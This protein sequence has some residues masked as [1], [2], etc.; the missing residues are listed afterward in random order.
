MKRKG[1][2]VRKELKEFYA[3]NKVL[4]TA[5]F[6][7]LGMAILVSAFAALKAGKKEDD[8]VEETMDKFLLLLG[9]Y[10]A[11]ERKVYWQEM[12]HLFDEGVIKKQPF[13]EYVMRVQ[14]YTH[15]EAVKY[16][17]ETFGMKESTQAVY[18]SEEFRLRR[19]EKAKVKA[20]RQSADH[21]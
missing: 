1:F 7:R 19:E 2:E 10:A 16:V 4:S 11:G 20:R 12:K 8:V 18:L 9:T 17:A 13:I 15:E 14:G 6:G 3:D 21:E 5:G